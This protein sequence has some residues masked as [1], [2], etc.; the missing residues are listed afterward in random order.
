MISLAFRGWR[1]PP[2]LCIFVCLD[3]TCSCCLPARCSYVKGRSH[4][5]LETKSLHRLSI[6][7]GRIFLPVYH[8]GHHHYHHHMSL[9]GKEDSRVQQKRWL[10]WLNSYCDV[11]SFVGTPGPY[12]VSECGRGGSVHTVKKCT[13]SV[14]LSLS[15][16][17]KSVS[18]LIFSGSL[19]VAYGTL[20]WSCDR[21]NLPGK[22]SL[23][24]LRNRKHQTS[25]TFFLWDSKIRCQN[26]VPDSS[27]LHL[28]LITFQNFSLVIS[29]II[30]KAHSWM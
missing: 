3:K 30:F 29:C 7:C 6:C 21:I 8:C 16:A 15:W 10:Q 27:N 17:S 9:G 25:V 26:I 4:K 1:V 5:A 18:S 11:T 13:F 22:N 24:R 19:D 14:S 20:F 12:A 2:R 28:P 23:I